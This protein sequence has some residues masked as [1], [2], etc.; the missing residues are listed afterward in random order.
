[1]LSLCSMPLT[2]DYYALGMLTD[3]H[4]ALTHY[5]GEHHTLAKALPPGNVLWAGEVHVKDGR[6][7]EANETSGLLARSGVHSDVSYLEAHLGYPIRAQHFT[8]EH[9]H[10]FPMPEHGVQSSNFRHDLRNQLVG[11]VFIAS[12]KERSTLADPA[13]FQVL[14]S[15]LPA[16]FDERTNHG[17]YRPSEY[18][19]PSEAWARERL[20]E[21]EQWF[22]G[23]GDF[24]SVAVSQVLRFLTQ[25]PEAEVL[26]F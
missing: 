13:A 21:F 3:G 6:I 7:V 20:Q 19:I 23:D 4:L 8:P 9:K 16:Y 18:H 24:D 5:L 22:K 12:T 15:M 25:E 11:I 1:M 2:K 26:D 17:I 10:L 14:Y